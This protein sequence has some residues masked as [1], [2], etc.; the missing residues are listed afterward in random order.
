MEWVWFWVVALR[1]EGRERQLFPQLAVIRLQPPPSPPDAQL[2]EK[3]Q[4][5]HSI[6][7]TAT[8]PFPITPLPLRHPDLWL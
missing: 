7:V 2:G 8:N 5:Y 1:G 3:P 6:I 4:H